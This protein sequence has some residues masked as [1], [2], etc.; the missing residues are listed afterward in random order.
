MVVGCARVPSPVGAAVPPASPGASSSSGANTARQ[1]APLTGLPAASAADAARPAVALD[2]AGPSP[3]GLATAD[4]V[5]E[6]ITSPVRYI[7]VYQS[8]DASGVGPITSTQP[9]D[10]AALTVL[11]PVIGYDGA[12][13]PYF[14]KFLDKSKIIDAGF[15]GHSSLYSSAAAGPT[16][17]T[18][19][20]LRAAGH[21][22]APQPLFSYRGAGAGGTLAGKEFR[23]TSVSVAIPG[24]G[25]QEWAFNQGADR[26]E[27]TRNGPKVAVANIIVQTVRYKQINVSRRQGI[28]VPTAEVTG[29]GKAEVFSGTV[30]GGGSGGS[31]AVGTWSK[32][33]PSEL[34]NY[35]DSTGTPMAFQPGPTWVIF[36]P[37][38]TRVSTSG[39]QG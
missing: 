35:F 30:S 23:C 24:L 6:E 3:S 29:N 11:R 4:L 25:T 16:T 33:H 31:G 9:T 17:S 32:P 20:I 12:T 34:T 1:I 15:T 7:A 10:R 28:V 27:L 14:I 8:R 37:S 36:A 39:A 21:A 18:R 13:A 38:A 19:D 22:T 2:V 26:W 5:F